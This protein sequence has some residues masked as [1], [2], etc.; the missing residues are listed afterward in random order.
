MRLNSSFLSKNIEKI[1]SMTSDL[2]KLPRK[3]S[4]LVSFYICSVL[5]GGLFN[6]YFWVIWKSSER[7]PRKHSSQFISTTIPITRRKPIMKAKSK[8]IFENSQQLPLRFK[9]AG[10]FEKLL[11][12]ARG[13]SIV[14]RGSVSFSCAITPHPSCFSKS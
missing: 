6:S 3:L 2:R 10:R 1:F 11:C 12:F 9:K 14:K 4:R 8:F 5:K 13:N 7:K